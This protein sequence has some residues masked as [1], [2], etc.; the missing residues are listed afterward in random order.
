[1][2]NMNACVI[3]FHVVHAPH[4]HVHSTVYCDDVLLSG[5]LYPLSSSII[6]RS[7]FCA[8]VKLDPHCE[9]VYALCTLMYDKPMRNKKE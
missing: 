8:S 9:C 2:R 6:C 7:S 5:V 1:M 4:I 3:I